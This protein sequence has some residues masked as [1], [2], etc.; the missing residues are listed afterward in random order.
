MEPVQHGRAFLAH[1][2]A[3]ANSRDTDHVFN[4]DGRVEGM[5][6]F[7]QCDGNRRAFAG[8][9]NKGLVLWLTG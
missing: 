6:Y 2:V 3:S 4:S 9:P 8:V 7:F 5:G 1:A